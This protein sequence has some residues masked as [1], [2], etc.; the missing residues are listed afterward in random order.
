MFDIVVNNA[1][2]FM[3]VDNKNIP[4]FDQTKNLM[5]TNVLGPITLTQK[6][7]PNLT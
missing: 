1:G 2:V 7:L 4:N 3:P 5:N 6:L